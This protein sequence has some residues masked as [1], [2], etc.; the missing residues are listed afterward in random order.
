[1]VFEEGGP[2]SMEIFPIGSNHITYDIARAFQVL[3]DEAEELKISYSTDAAIKRKLNS[4]IEPRL[5]DI[6]ELVGNHLNK[7]HR[8]GLMPAGVILTGGGANLLGV[9]E[10]AKRSLKLPSQLS[11]SKFSEDF[12]NEIINPVWSVAFGLCCVGFNDSDPIGKAGSKA[13]KV[14]LRWVKTFMP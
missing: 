6:F 11:Q 2:I 10:V 13:K 8:V 5:N 7:I 9:E 4:I 3:L 12:K 14:L 1:V